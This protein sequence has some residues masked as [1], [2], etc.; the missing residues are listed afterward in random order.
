M[1]KIIG[2]E[3]SKKEIYSLWNLSSHSPIWLITVKTSRKA[4]DLAEEYA[5]RYGINVGIKR[6]VV[7]EDGNI[8]KSE[9]IRVVKP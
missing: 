8:I 3:K 1:S 7:D 6:E 5:E 4:Y 2:V 9:L